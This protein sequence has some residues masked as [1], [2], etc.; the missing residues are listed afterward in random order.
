MAEDVKASPTAS[1]GEERASTRMVT[2]LGRAG[3]AGYFGGA[4]AIMGLV[5]LAQ[6]ALMVILHGLGYAPG[7]LSAAPA[8]YRAV[9]FAVQAAFLAGGLWA[10]RR[11]P[12]MERPLTAKVGRPQAA[13]GEA[14]DVPQPQS[15]RLQSP[16]WQ[17]VLSPVVALAVTLAGGVAGGVVRGLTG[18]RAMPASFTGFF[19]AM[20]L[21]GAFL[22]LL[23]GAGLMEEFIYR[24]GLQNALTRWLGPWAGWVLSAVAFGLYHVLPGFTSIDFSGM[25]VSQFASSVVVGL[26]FGLAYRYLGLVTVVLAHTLGNFAGLLMMR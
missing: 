18:E 7:G 20:P 25:R 24:Y 14:G 17:F 9:G 26:G 5:A 2:W 10:T 15:S 8:A 16:A 13:G 22:A 23:L 21:W 11:L 1:S 12:F 6:T 19:G 4:I 3:A